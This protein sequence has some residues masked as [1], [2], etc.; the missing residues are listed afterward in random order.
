M[1]VCVSCVCVYPV[2]VCVCLSCVCVCVYIW[3]ESVTG[4]AWFL[5]SDTQ[6]P[7]RLLPRLP[8]CCCLWLCTEQPSRCPLPPP[9]APHPVL[10]LPAPLWRPQEPASCTGLCLLLS[11]GPL[12]LGFVSAGLWQAL[13]PTLGGARAPE[14][15]P[16]A[17]DRRPV[18]TI[19]TCKQLHFHASRTQVDAVSATATL[20]QLRLERSK[21]LNI[22]CCTKT[23]LFKPVGGWKSL[24]KTFG[25]GILMVTWDRSSLSYM[26]KYENIRIQ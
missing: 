5:P 8:C 4:L 14:L 22:L 18:L 2:C 9:P 20:L 17:Q 16:K 21:I 19:S 23:N 6:T 7:G 3:E 13:N 10:L 11:S 15:L 1:C 26:H 25:R 12:V 24:I